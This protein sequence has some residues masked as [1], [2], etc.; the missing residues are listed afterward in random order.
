MA[1]AE[2]T[3]P[4]EHARA[5]SGRDWRTIVLASLG[6]GIEY[7]DFIVYAT[8]ASYI[9]AK[10]FPS[11]DPAVSLLNTFAVFGAGY[12]IRPLGGMILGS[13]G[14]R[15]G[16]R[17]IFLVSLFVISMATLGMALTPSYEKIGIVAPVVFLLLRLSQ[18][19]C[20]GGEQA[21]ALTYVIEVAPHRAGLACG[22]VF[23]LNVAGV[24]IANVISNYIHSSFSPTEVAD[25]GWR[26][27][28][29]V[30]A[31]FG[32]LGMLLRRRLDESPEFLKMQNH[33]LAAPL[34]ELFRNYKS[35]LFVG[36][37]IV[38]PL[39]ILGGLL[40]AH[41]PVYL[42][43]SIGVT[44]AAIPN[45]IATG[46][47]VIATSS[48]LYGWL[49]DYVGQRTLYAIGALCILAGAWPAYYLLST[50]SAEPLK[51]IVISG[52]FT[53]M[54][55]GTL[56]P[57][58]AQLFPTQVRFTGYG[59]CYN[60]GNAIFQGFSPLLATYLLQ[61]TGNLTAP[62]YIWMGGAI[63]ALIGVSRHVALGRKLSAADLGRLS[64]R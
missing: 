62:S 53:A 43:K 49:S 58:I 35:Q 36:T 48:L 42:S 17:K 27:A 46:S 38:A 54:I 4:N 64:E 60:V 40:F 10:I 55:T 37:V 57:L 29:A 44:P 11:T 32:L 16:R 9:S 15:Y 39:A 26:I 2:P 6:N 21:G 25:Y 61:V 20:Y 7:Y 18:G 22:F 45:I 13:F 28:F 23:F 24:I 52:F 33:V 8:F 30:G 34:S 50:H 12:L 41:M 5:V 14:D 51:I 59:F 31:G 47:I 63:L 3:M 56:G 1:V 19:L